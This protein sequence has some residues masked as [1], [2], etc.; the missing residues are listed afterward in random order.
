MVSPYLSANMRQSV[1]CFEKP[2]DTEAVG[3]LRRKPRGVHGRETQIQ[4]GQAATEGC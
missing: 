1:V 4:S 2:R 3:E